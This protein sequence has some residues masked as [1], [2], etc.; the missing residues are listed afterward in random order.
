MVSEREGS[1]VRTFTVGFEKVLKS[2][3]LLFAAFPGL[4]NTLCTVA[5]LKVPAMTVYD[6]ETKVLG[7]ELFAQHNI[8]DIYCFIQS[9]EAF[10]VKGNKHTHIHASSNYIV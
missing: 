10:T 4:I 8:A 2:S 9:G 7:T 1:Y 6:V 5:S 3:L